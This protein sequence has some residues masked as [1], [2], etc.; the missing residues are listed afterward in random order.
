MGKKKNTEIE[1]LAWEQQP[2]ESAKKYEAFLHYMMMKTDEDERSLRKVASDLNKSLTYIGTLSSEF[3]WVE[4]VEAWDSEQARLATLEHQK[5]IKKKREQEYKS[6][7]VL[8]KKALALLSSVDNAKLSEI[9]TALKTGY[10][11]MGRGLGD[12]GDVIEVRDGGQAFDPVQIY[13][14]DN[15]RNDEDTFDDLKV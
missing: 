12:V 7:N 4:R 3:K 1:L 6:G 13:I 14:P 10:D 5:K 15:K 9:V 2:G 11:M 8:A